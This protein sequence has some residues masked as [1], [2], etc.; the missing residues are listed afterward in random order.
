MC[1]LAVGQV[2]KGWQEGVG[3]MKVGGKAVLTIPPSLAYGDMPIG[4]I[5]G[6][7]ALRFEVELLEATEPKKGLFGFGS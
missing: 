6:G 4:K 3:L 2:I 7:S 1:W 5:P